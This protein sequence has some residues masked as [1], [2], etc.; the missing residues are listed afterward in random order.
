M[1]VAFPRGPHGLFVLS[2]S[3][4]LARSPLGPAIQRHLVN[5][6]YVCGAAVFVNWSGVD[7]GPGANP[8]Y[9]W[10]LVDSLITPWA[11][12]KKIVNIELNGSGYEGDVMHAVPSYVRSQVQTVACGNDVAP[13]Y[14]QSA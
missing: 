5:N 8:R 3:E 10:T 2:G 1:K 11:E 7:Q 12:A 9:D 6:P 4:P 13:V 14:W